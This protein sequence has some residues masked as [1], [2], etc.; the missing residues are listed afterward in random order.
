MPTSCGAIS[1]HS[2]TSK[3]MRRTIITLRS[4]HHGRHD[5]CSELHGFDDIRDV[6]AEDVSS[7]CSASSSRMGFYLALFRTE[8][9]RLRA[10]VRLGRRSLSVLPR[11]SKVTLLLLPTITLFENGRRARPI[12]P[13]FSLSI[14]TQIS[15]PKRG[16]QCQDHAMVI[17]IPF[18]FGC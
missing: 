13:C 7:L 18:L 4:K 17:W 15:V 3:G 1:L 12:Q 11:R 16:T 8:F 6:T 9:F 10:Y 5:K 14:V 2:R